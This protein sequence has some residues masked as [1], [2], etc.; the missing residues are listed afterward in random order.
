VKSNV[1]GPTDGLYSTA[2]G[3]GTAQQN[4][5]AGGGKG[6]YAMILFITP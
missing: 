1:F 2:G 4:C 5:W 3:N 6:G